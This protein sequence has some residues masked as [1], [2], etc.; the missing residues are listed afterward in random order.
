[1]HCNINDNGEESTRFTSEISSDILPCS[2][3]TES[4]NPTNADSGPRVAD[5]DT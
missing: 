1:M 5:E 3:P 2:H 4:V